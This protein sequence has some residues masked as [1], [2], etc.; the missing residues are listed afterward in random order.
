MADKEKMREKITEDQSILLQ[1]SDP[2]NSAVFDSPAVKHKLPLYIYLQNMLLAFGYNTLDAIREH[3][4][5]SNDI[6]RMCRF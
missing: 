2:V 6:G 5:G 4:P 3:E 1:A